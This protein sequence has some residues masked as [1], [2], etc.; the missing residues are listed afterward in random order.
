MFVVGVLIRA[1]EEYSVL[2]LPDPVGP[3]TST[4]PHGFSIATSVD[5]EILLLDEVL[6]TAGGSEP[7]GGDLEDLGPEVAEAARKLPG[8]FAGPGDDNAPAKERAPL[9]PVQ[10]VAQLYDAADDGHDRWA[11]AG[12]A[13]YSG[14]VSEGAFDG[15][16]LARGSVPRQRHRRFG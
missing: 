15:L 14:D 8:L 10:L 6:A 5:P 16:R 7:D 4:M 3:V 9:E 12:L 13:R 11:E 2:V 1:I